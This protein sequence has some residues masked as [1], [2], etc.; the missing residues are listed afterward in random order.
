MKPRSPCRL[1]K[2]STLLIQKTQDNFACEEGK[3][4][5]Q[6]CMELKMAMIL[7]FQ[8]PPRLCSNRLSKMRMTQ[9]KAQITLKV[10]KV[11]LLRI[12]SLEWDKEMLQPLPSVKMWSILIWVHLALLRHLKKLLF[13]PRSS[14]D[15]VLILVLTSSHVWKGWTRPMRR[16]LRVD[17]KENQPTQ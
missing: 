7:E 17:Q 9:M 16:N 14:P 6:V 12:S 3:R 5:L 2:I 8:V 15:I 13:D 11:Y 4:L 10:K 1:T